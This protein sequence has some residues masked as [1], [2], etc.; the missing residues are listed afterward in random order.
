MCFILAISLRFWLEH[1]LL[2]QR[3][4]SG[5]VFGLFVSVT[6][7]PAGNNECV[8]YSKGVNIFVWETAAFIDYSSSEVLLELADLAAV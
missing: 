2:L 1:L 4:S 5:F 8:V 3:E 7:S 6:D